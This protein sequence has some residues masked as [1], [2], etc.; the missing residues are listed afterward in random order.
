MKSLVLYVRP[1]C[2]LCEDMEQAL[3]ALGAGSRFQL[4]VRD[5]EQ[6]AALEASY[7][8]LIPIL[9]E[10]QREICRY[11]LDRERLQAAL[12]HA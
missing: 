9:F 5:V 8:E 2:H 12:S 3:R 10:D 7:G 11:H 6:D 4:S 1:G